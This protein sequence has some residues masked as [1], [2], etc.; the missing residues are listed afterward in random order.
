MEITKEIILLEL[1][2][3]KYT[4]RNLTTSRF[5][6]IFSE[7]TKKVENLYEISLEKINNNEDKRTT[8][9]IQNLPL[10]MTKEGLCLKLSD[11]GNINFLY[12]PY[13]KTNKKNFGFVYINFI[14]YKSI[15]N[16]YKKFQGRFLSEYYMEAPLNIIY[17]KIQGKAK[18]SQMFTK[19]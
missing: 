2:F 1:L 4:K 14:N 17:S 15:I 13:D 12:L 3:P 19:K 18:L 6:N 5:T 16:A 10:D 7:E 8:I 9:V 11:I